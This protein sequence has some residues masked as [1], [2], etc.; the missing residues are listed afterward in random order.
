[1]RAE[2]PLVIFVAP[3]TVTSVAASCVTT[4][5]PAVFGRLRMSATTHYAGL[6]IAC[7]IVHES[8]RVKLKFAE[9]ICMRNQRGQGIKQKRWTGH[10]R[11]AVAGY[12]EAGDHRR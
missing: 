3:Q 4:S 7:S 5:R 9:A 6:N 11:Q 8:A 12:F 1:M 10:H 2:R